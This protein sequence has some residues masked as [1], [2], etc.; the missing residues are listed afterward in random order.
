MKIKMKTDTVV[1]K[2]KARHDCMHI[3]LIDTKSAYLCQDYLQDVTPLYIKL[4]K[5]VAEVINL[6]PKQTY[7]I[8]KYIYGLPDA[9][10]AYYDAYANHLMEN[11]FSRTASDPCLSFKTTAPTRRVY[12]WIHVDDTLIA[13]DELEDI[14]LDDEAIF[15]ITV[16]AEADHNLGVNIQR[17]PNCSLKL[18]QSKLSNTVFEE[19][20]DAL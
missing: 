14:E 17:I 9:G 13:A 1:D 12:V 6:N 7:R 4:P 16:N 10:R 18:T 5:R 20:R 3:Q 8:L 19:C 2:L 15:E 11:G